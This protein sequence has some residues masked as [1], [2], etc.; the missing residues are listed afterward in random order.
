MISSSA[1]CHLPGDRDLLHGD[2]ARNY[3]TFRVEDIVH[4]PSSAIVVF[5]V[6][7]SGSMA[8]EHRWLGTAV[9]ALEENLQQ[10]GVGNLVAN[11]YALV[12]FAHTGAVRG[13]VIPVGK[14]GQ[15]CGNASQLATA[16]GNLQ[17]DGKLEDGYSAINL[18]LKGVSCL[19]VSSW[20]FLQYNNNIILALDINVE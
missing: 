19:Q 9:T 13:R 4:K 15:H 5:V 2:T 6:D 12:G 16:L 1:Q 8:G 10:T 20:H 7:E 11:R 3:S 18:A 17:V 14:N